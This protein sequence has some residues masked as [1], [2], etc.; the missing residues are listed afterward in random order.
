MTNTQQ[1]IALTGATD[2][3]GR[4]L[5]QH[6]ST[7]PI[8]LILHGRSPEKLESLARELAG[9]PASIETVV[10]DLSDLRQVHDLAREISA[11]AS[12]ISVLVNNAGAGAGEPYGT[13]RQLTVDGNELR[14][15]VNYLAA[16]ALTNDLL[17]LLELG[18]P[19]RVVNVASLGQ[20]PID[21]DDLTLEH[22]YDGH[23]AYC[24]SKLAMIT[25]GIALAK[26]LDPS[27]VTVNSLHPA[28]F[29]PT[30]MVM[31]SEG[32]S[33][34]SLEAGVESTLR[35]ILDP[36]LDGVTGHFFDRASPSR[37][38]EDAYDSRIQDRLWDLSS[39]LTARP[40]H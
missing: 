22:N 17:P 26:R 12:H 7:Q 23:R 27:K 1:V 30:K 9:S 15:A 39:Q 14:F 32:R 34:D 40:V 31:E 19:S 38:H 20:M 18:A 10:A 36:E 2:G 6:L 13:I 11:L 37:A 28:T 5:A 8:F 4:A 33:V 25:S 35:L 29:M 16:F 3:L 21:F 24:Q